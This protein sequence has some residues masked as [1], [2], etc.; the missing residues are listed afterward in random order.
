[1]TAM[2]S[3]GLVLPDIII[4]TL[5]ALA[6]RGDTQ[7]W[8]IGD[9]LVGVVDEIKKYVPD[10]GYTPEVV[11]RARL[12]RELADR[13]G[14]DAS[15]LRDREVMARFFTHADREAYHALTYHQLRACKGG[16]E[17]WRE[18]ADRAMGSLPAPVRVIRSWV[19]SNG[20]GESRHDYYL[21]RLKEQAGA[22]LDSNPPAGMRLLARLVL[23][24]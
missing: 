8:E 9:F 1:M 21:R 5:R 4:E 15:T 20:D 10:E 14:L 7:Q 13:T 16:G 23:V 3:G 2:P 11:T 18:Y 17:R 6:N 22:L 24:W 19:S 12:L